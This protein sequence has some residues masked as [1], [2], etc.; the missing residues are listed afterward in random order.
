MTSRNI[1]LTGWRRLN[2]LSDALRLRYAPR[3]AELFAGQLQQI[4]LVTI[5]L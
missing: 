2:G 4:D 5:V 3:D 1:W